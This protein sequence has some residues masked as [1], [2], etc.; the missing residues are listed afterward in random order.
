MLKAGVP[1]NENAIY[2]HFAWVPAY[3][4]QN[5]INWLF[6]QKNNRIK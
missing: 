1:V 6:S 5:A 2:Y 3:N 4:N